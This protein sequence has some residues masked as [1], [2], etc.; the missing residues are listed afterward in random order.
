MARPRAIPG[1]V[2]QEGTNQTPEAGEQIAP[3]AP[4]LV[5]N[6]ERLRERLNHAR[7]KR[8]TE[9][10]ARSTLHWPVATSSAIAQAVTGASNMPLRK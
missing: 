5:T 3:N 10:G 4:S 6:D 9:N 1:A 8:V 7:A 2:P